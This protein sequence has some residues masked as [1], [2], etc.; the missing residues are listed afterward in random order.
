MKRCSR[1]LGALALLTVLPLTVAC[2]PGERQ[3]WDRWFKA[4]P[5]AAQTEL[6]KRTPADIAS[7]APLLDDTQLAALTA[8]VEAVEALTGCARYERWLDQAGLPAHFHGV[9]WRESKCIPTARNPSGASGL[10]QVMP[11]WASRCGITVALLFD[12]LQNI[13]CGVVVYRAQGG[14]AWETW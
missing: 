11:M 1:L 9:M 8:H 4:E 12:P 13:L 14:A 5:I 3:L 6:A 7:D 2:S 10:L